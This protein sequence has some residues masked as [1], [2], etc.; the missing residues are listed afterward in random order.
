MSES[1]KKFQTY[2]VQISGAVKD[3]DGGSHHAWI[4][5]AM[6]NSTELG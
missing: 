3:S 4:V 2:D 5:P 1:V 6:F